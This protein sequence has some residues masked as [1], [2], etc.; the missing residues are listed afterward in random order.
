MSQLFPFRVRGNVTLC[1]GGELNAPP[2]KARPRE[3]KH[4]ATSDD[5]QSSLTRTVV[6]LRVV[7]TQQQRSGTTLK[8]ITIIMREDAARSTI[9]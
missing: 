9:L 8:T 3:D 4:F 5:N 7:S 6:I 1:V 2:Q